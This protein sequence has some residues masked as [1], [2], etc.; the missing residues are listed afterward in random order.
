M[1]IALVTAVWQRHGITAL[2]WQWAQQLRSWWPEH[3]V[4]FVAA[5]SDDPRHEA[6]AHLAGAVYV[7]A[8]NDPLG[9]KFNAAV[10][11]ARSLHPDA[12]LIMGSDDVFC[13]GV[14]DAYRPYLADR[15][16]LVGLE[17][18]SFYDTADGRLGY[19]GGY[20]ELRRLGEPAGSGRVVGAA[21]L[22][23]MGWQ[24][25]D[26]HEHEGMDHSAF[27]R[28][29]EVGAPPYTLIT[30]REHGIALALKS[31]VNL[32]SYD[33][34]LGHAAGL[35]TDRSPLDG[36]DISLRIGLA[37]L[38]EREPVARQVLV[39]IE[40]NGRELGYRLMDA[41]VLADTRCDG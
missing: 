24:V 31:A 37:A 38:R 4:L 17:D 34:I 21:W 12:L 27:R 23:R 26:G 13:R 19:W 40:V 35:R 39:P 5:G 29:H 11:A 16:V 1:R 2:F 25:W 36:L 33:H 15:A 32:W 8:P 14:A 9:G 18:F 3:D 7:N 22:D 10:A 30:S 28:L 6:M 20:Q 41:T